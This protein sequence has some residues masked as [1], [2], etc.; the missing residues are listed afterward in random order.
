M[1]VDIAAV[2]K[3]LGR[4]IRRRREAADLSQEDL[5]FQA[6]VHR[7]YVSML[8]RGTGNPSLAVI[9]RLANVLD[10]SLTSLMQEVESRGG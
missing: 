10:A 5:A 2:Q 7:T 4:V 3:R 9:V 6:G 8:E 1:A